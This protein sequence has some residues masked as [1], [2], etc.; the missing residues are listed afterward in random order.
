MG[1]EEV[2][3]G[4]EEVS[5]VVGDTRDQKTP[6]DPLVGDEEVGAYPSEGGDD[7]NRKPP[8]EGGPRP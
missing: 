7:Y 8:E 1:W 4:A 3:Q 6:Q 2:D 5:G